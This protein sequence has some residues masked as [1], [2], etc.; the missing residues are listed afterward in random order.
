ML[1]TVYDL[2]VDPRVIG[3]SL[4]ALFVKSITAV[5]KKNEQLISE[6]NDKR[7][8]LYIKQMQ[9]RLFKFHQA[10]KKKKGVNKGDSP[11]FE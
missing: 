11:P 4:A 3:S 6:Q 9:F 8:I 5:L 7:I 1:I 10:Q 2:L